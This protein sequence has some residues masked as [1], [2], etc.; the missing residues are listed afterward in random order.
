MVRAPSPTQELPQVHCIDCGRFLGF[1]AVVVGYV[2]IKCPKCK[3]WTTISNF[4]EELDNSTREGYAE[5]R[6][7]A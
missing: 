4:P 2:Q 5:G 3:G 7:A 1:A 6:K